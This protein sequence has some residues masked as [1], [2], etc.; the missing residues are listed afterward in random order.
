MII[1][2]ILRYKSFSVVNDRYIFFDYISNRFINELIE[3][4]FVDG[5]YDD[6]YE[7]IYN[8]ITNDMDIVFKYY[9]DLQDRI[10]EM[11]YPTEAFYYLIINI[12]KIYHLLDLGRYFIDKWINTKSKVVRLIPNINKKTIDSKISICSLIDSL[13]KN[14]KLSIN[15]IKRIKLYEGEFYC[16]CGL[17]SIVPIIDG[18]NINEVFD[19]INYV[20]NTYNYLLE[21]Y[22]KEQKKDKDNF[23]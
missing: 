9:N 10:E 3:N 22:E 18:K 6:K 16:L 20:D 14:S 5:N 2:K 19:I 17:I 15:D 7:D 12:S 1:N 21:K 11:F 13:Y 23:K 8:K 4:Y